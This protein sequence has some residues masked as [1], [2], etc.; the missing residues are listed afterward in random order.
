MDKMRRRVRDGERRN[1]RGRKDKRG[2][3]GGI[4]VRGEESVMEER[5]EEKEERKG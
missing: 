3:K 5:E 1:E 2:G 4:K